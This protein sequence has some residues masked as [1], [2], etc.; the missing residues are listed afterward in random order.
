M[1]Q[2]LKSFS[3]ANAIER[4]AGADAIGGPI[5]VSFDADVPSPF[6]LYLDYKDNQKFTVSGPSAFDRVELR[7]GDYEPWNLRPGEDPLPL[8]DGIVCVC[9]FRIETLTMWIANNNETNYIITL[10]IR[11]WLDGQKHP[12]DPQIVLPPK[13]HALGTVK[14]AQ[15]RLGPASGRGRGSTR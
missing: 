9:A 14:A 1:H 3:P 5:T 2:N 6:K 8:P 4:R 10:H 7:M 15:D 12:S 13:G 11:F